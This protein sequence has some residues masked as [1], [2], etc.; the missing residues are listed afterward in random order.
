MGLGAE[1]HGEDP[2]EQ[3]GILLP[4][5]GDLRG[6]RGGGPGVHDVGIP[7]ESTGHAALG[8][9]VAVGD[10]GGRVDGQPVL[11]G[12]QRDVEVDLPVVGR[13]GTRPE[14]EPR[15]NVDG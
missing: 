14:R 10:I 11:V 4:P 6:E 3:V 13:P 2:G 7:D 8:L 5:S 1:I 15:R 9:A 12:Q